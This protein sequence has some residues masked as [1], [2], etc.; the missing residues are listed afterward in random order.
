MEIADDFKLTL[1]VG[2]PIGILGASMML[3]ND[4]LPILPILM[5]VG[6][7]ASFGLGKCLLAVHPG[8]VPLAIS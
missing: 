2:P 3:L 5:E 6:S 4:K 1:H 8:P 7:T